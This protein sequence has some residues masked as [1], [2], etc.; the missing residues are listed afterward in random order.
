MFECLKSFVRDE[1]GVV[2]VDW[3]V[4]AAALV[5]LAVG[6]LLVFRQPTLD[7]WSA[8]GSAISRVEVNTTLD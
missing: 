3:V 4:L 8:I 1:H 2:T 6:I 5:G 7:T